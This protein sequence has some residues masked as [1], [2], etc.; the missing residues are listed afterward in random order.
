MAAYTRGLALGIP[1]IIL[2]TILS[3][4][5]QMDSGRKRVLVSVIVDFVCD[6]LFNL[7]AVY[8]GMGLFG[9][10]LATSC[11]RYIRLGVLLFH[12]RDQSHLLHFVPLKTS[13]KEFIH[14]LSMGTEKAW[15]RLGNVIRPIVIN[16]MVLLAGGTMAMTA[17]SVRGN[18]SDVTEVLAVGLADTVGLLAGIYYGEKNMEA[19]RALGKSAHRSTFIFCISV[20]ILLILLSGPIAGFYTGDHTETTALTRFALIGVALQCPLQALIRSRISYLQRIQKSMNMKLLILVATAVYPILSALILDALFGIYGILLCYTV[21]DLLSLVT[22]WG[23]YAVKKKKGIPSVQDY[24]NLPDDFLVNPG[25]V[26][27]LDIRNLEDVSLGAEQIEL[28]CR[29][30]KIDWKTGNRVSVCFEEMASNT[31]KHGFPLNCSKAPIID[32][33][34]VYS[35]DKLMIRLQDN[36]P[37]FDVGARIKAMANSKMENPDSE[38][39]TRLTVKLADS[40]KYAYCYET[41][42]VFLDFLLDPRDQPGEAPA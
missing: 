13:V 11:G 25:D 22:V 16:K 4:A 37:K 36:C 1:A 29:G 32:L 7:L 3:P 41:N 26:I 21:S 40:V 30:H 17:M 2:N 33:L 9:I 8:L 20:A 24:L 15:R 19:E 6:S 35:P 18:V 23:Y 34:V 38:I 14:L 39:G 12:F 31:V 5:I 27:S 42:I 10:G 28:F